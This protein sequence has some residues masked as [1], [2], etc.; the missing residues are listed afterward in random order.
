MKTIQRRTKIEIETHEVTIV[1]LGSG[2]A[3]LVCE[4]CGRDFKDGA[5]TLLSS[6]DDASSA[7]K[8]FAGGIGDG[9]KSVPTPSEEIPAGTENLL[10]H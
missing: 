10:Q 3:R 7:V 8:Y 2:D 5:R 6:T 9:D 4:N 1:R